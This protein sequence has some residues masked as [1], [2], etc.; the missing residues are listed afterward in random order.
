[1][2]IFFDLDGTLIDSRLRLYKLFQDLVSNSNLT[3]S[4]YWSL[5]RNKIKHKKILTTKFGY[6]EKDFLQFEDKWMAKIE[7]EE[8]LALDTPF[9]D[10]TSFLNKLANSHK[11]FVITA[12]QFET[13]TLSQITRFG[14]E[15]FFSMV[16]VTEQKKEKYKLLKD[17]VN[18]TSDD[19]I[20][21]DSGIEIITGKVLKINTAAVLSGFLNKKQLSQYQ[22]DVILNNVINFNYE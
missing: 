16:L 2:N 3:F 20:I 4:D 1:M 17:N 13:S 19:W 8:Y 15:N 6:T 10:T 7:Q 12:R 22:P 21:G 14:W 11:L 9:L 5:K 18:L